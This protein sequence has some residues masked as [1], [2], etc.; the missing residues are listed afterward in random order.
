MRQHHR[1]KSGGDLPPEVPEEIRARHERNLRRSNVIFALSFLVA[2]GVHLVILLRGP[3]FEV[4]IPEADPGPPAMDVQ[5]DV[6]DVGSLLDVTF[7]PPVIL[8]AD[9]SLRPEPPERVLEAQQVDASDTLGSSACAGR[10]R[11]SIV[12][13][14]GRVHVRV[15]Q[16]GRVIRA[17][18]RESLGDPC[19]DRLIAEISGSVWYRWLPNEEHPAPVDLIQPVRVTGGGV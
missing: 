6:V 8:A 10:A 12:P 15:N 14:S 16:H 3:I 1:E 13:F 2:L 17:E 18:V 9:G 7:L 19:R 4:E 11:D 5:I